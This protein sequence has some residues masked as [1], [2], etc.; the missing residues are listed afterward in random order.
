[1]EKENLEEFDDEFQEYRDCMLTGY[2]MIQKYQVH[3]IRDLYLCPKYKLYRVQELLDFFTTEG[4]YEKCEDLIGIRSVLE[5]QMFFVDL[6]GK[7]ELEIG[8]H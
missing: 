3:F 5:V 4:D 1:M 7:K 2:S 6:Y 8:Y